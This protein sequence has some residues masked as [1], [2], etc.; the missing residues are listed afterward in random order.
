MV[1]V[2]KT[3]CS[4][5]TASNEESVLL[6][7]NRKRKGLILTT[8]NAD[9]WI[10]FYEA[11]E[12][13]DGTYEPAPMDNERCQV[14]IKASSPLPLFLTQGVTTWGWLTCMNATE[15]ETPTIHAVELI[16]N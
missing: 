8:L 5:V 4:V 14:L 9:A 11:I 16:D 6:E 13:P 2:D 3:N 10:K 7:P 1:I 12:K 15:N